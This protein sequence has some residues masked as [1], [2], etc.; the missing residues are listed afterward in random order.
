MSWDA[1]LTDNYGDEI[2]DWNYTHNT[3]AMIYEALSR[4][5][6][7]LSKQERWYT[8]LDGM[9]G[10]E[11]RTYLTTIVRQLEDEPATFKAMNPQ[12]GWGDYDGLLRILREMRDRVPDDFATRWEA[13]G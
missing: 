4:A 2:G 11:G 1:T 7:A 6:V 5:G 9:W 3:S 12:N 10:T 13:G 8:R